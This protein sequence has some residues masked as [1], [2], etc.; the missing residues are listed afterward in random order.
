LS[1]RAVIVAAIEYPK[2][3]REKKIR[4]LP[5]KFLL[6]P[7]IRDALHPTIAA[8]KVSSPAGKSRRSDNA[9]GETKIAASVSTNKVVIAMAYLLS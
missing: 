2:T 7:N 3:A 8:T 6:P 5:M 1:S 4:T 9:G